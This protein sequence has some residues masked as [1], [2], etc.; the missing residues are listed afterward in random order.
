VSTQNLRSKR[1]R[2]T[3]RTS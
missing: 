2:C 3:L 1:Y